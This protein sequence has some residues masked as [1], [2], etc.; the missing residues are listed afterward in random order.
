MYALIPKLNAALEPLLIIS[1]VLPNVSPLATPPFLNGITAMLV[2]MYV[3]P[4]VT[5]AALEA[6]QI[7]HLEKLLVDL[8]LTATL[9]QLQ[10]QPQ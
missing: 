9:L 4:A 3:Q 1:L 8:P 2:Q 6:L 10:P 5:N 7:W